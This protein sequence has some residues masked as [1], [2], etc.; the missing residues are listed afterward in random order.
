VLAMPT[1]KAIRFSIDPHGISVNNTH[2]GSI[3]EID[4]PNGFCAR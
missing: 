3:V 4:C 1:N 2:L